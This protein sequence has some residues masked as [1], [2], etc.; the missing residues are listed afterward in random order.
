MFLKIIDLFFSTVYRVLIKFIISPIQLSSFGSAGHN[1]R[2][3]RNSIFNK[4]KHIYL[5]NNVSIGPNAVFYAM[6]ANIYIGDNVMFGPNVT[7]SAGGH[8]IDNINIPMALCKEKNKED[9]KDIIIHNDVWIGAN[10]IILKGVEI[11]EG[12]VIGA[13]SV[14]TKSTIPYGIYVGNPANLLRYREG[15]EK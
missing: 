15:K 5:G 1:C 3:N 12:C 10:S 2:I 14:V 4:K 6:I 8:R 9:D 7:I 13:G 11:G